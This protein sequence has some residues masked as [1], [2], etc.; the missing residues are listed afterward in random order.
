M[1]PGYEEGTGGGDQDFDRLQACAGY[2]VFGGF[3]VCQEGGISLKLNWWKDTFG[4][5]AS[6]FCLSIL[7][8]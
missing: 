8:I 7:Q 5:N 3:F 4:D 2:F 1:V 6:V